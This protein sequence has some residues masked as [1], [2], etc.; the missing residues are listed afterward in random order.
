MCLDK[1][2]EEISLLSEAG[3]EFISL[4]RESFLDADFESKWRPAK[5]QLIHNKSLQVA[6]EGMYT[7][8][9]FCSILLESHT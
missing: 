8:F 2:L 6:Y 9:V 5:I 4:I 1:T 7:A 3:E